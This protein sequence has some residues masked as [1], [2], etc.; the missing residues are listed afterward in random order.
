MKSNV[1]RK[2]GSLERSSIRRCMLAKTAPTRLLNPRRKTSGTSIVPLRDVL[3]TPDVP[4]SLDEPLVRRT[5]AD[6]RTSHKLHLPSFETLGIAARHPHYFCTQPHLSNPTGPPRTHPELEGIVG[7]GLH[8]STDLGNKAYRRPS[9][10]ALQMLTPPDD[11][12]TIDWTPSSTT[13]IDSTNLVPCPTSRAMSTHEG[14]P[15]VTATNPGSSEGHQ[16]SETREQHHGDQSM[17]NSS[18]L[19][20]GQNDEGDSM[21]QSLLEQA[22]GITG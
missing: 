11:S 13:A 21:D 17:E 3:R 1:D 16:P 15:F 9:Q 22:I 8:E 12:G 14:A 20:P 19:P 2:D 6:D 5:S 18:E 7:L 10:V 4:A